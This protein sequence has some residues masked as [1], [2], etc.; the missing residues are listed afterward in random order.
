MGTYFVEISW[1]RYLR[2]RI[3]KSKKSD[4]RS[5]GEGIKKKISFFSF[6][7][8]SIDYKYSR[9]SELGEHE[10]ETMCKLL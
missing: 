2:K 1:L 10:H 5:Q 4:M 6:V 7:S 3:R 9:E 8:S